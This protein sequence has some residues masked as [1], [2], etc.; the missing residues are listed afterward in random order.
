MEYLD[1]LYSVNYNMAL[2]LNYSRVSKGLVDPIPE[3]CQGLEG[4]CQKRMSL[5]KGSMHGKPG[6]GLLIRRSY[7]NRS[8]KEGKRLSDS[9]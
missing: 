6:G 2:G 5:L 4:G 8:Q 7:C 3:A 1:F 9:V